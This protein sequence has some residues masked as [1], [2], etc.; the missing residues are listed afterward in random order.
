MVLTLKNQKYSFFNQ[1]TVFYNFSHQM[2]PMLSV[3]KILKMGICI[4]GLMMN[5]ILRQ[6]LSSE[7]IND[8]LYVYE[9][10]KEFIEKT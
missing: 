7:N 2:K 6:I 5:F 3:S 10:S 9:Y 1:N 8:H 4:K